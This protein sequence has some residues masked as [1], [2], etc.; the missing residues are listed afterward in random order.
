MS[1]KDGSRRDAEVV[2]LDAFRRRRGEPAKTPDEK[3]PEPSTKAQPE[4][5]TGELPKGSAELK[6]IVELMRMAAKL[7][8]L[9][10]AEGVISRKVY[11][12]WRVVFQKETDAEVCDRAR[13]VDEKAVKS[14]PAYIRALFDEIKRRMRKYEDLSEK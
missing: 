7:F 1:E 13:Y 3:A 11:G 2:Q 14:N 8:R 6:Q 9:P 12:D 4:D 10:K 5:A